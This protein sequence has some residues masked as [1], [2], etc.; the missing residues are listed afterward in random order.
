MIPK[1]TDLDKLESNLHHTEGFEL[2]TEQLKVIDDL[3]MGL[4]YVFFMSGSGEVC[5]LYDSQAQ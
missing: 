3:D 2:S 5:S 1:A 4:R